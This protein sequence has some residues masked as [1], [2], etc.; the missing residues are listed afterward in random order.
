MKHFYARAFALIFVPACVY[1]FWFWVHFNILDISGPGDAFM[2]AKFQATL[3]GN[4]LTA[5]ATSKNVTY[6]TSQPQH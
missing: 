6:L 4:P 1:L 5:M 3:K 2:S